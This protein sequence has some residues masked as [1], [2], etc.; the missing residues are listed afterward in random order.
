MTNKSPRSENGKRPR[1]KLLD[2]NFS[3]NVNEV[4]S[5]G[6]RPHGGLR[7]KILLS[8]LLFNYSRGA[9]CLINENSALII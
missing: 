7:G 3:N 4:L 2:L 6:V 9:S 5:N 1:L 8:C